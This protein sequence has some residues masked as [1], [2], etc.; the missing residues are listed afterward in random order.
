M[1]GSREAA[2]EVRGEVARMF[3]ERYPVNYSGIICP[4]S[5]VFAKEPFV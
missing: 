4:C 5:H 1:H 2:C 3:L